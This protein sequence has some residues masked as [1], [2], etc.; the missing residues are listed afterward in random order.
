MGMA[1][2]GAPDIHK[3]CRVEIVHSV[4]HIVHRL[5]LLQVAGE[6]LEVRGAQFNGDVQIFLQAC[7]DRFTERGLGLGWLANPEF[8]GGEVLAVGE[9][10]IGQQFAGLFGIIDIGIKRLQ[11]LILVVGEAGGN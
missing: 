9:A 6:G 7:L 11:G 5:V 1:T 4:A 10:G 3:G 2:G 8:K